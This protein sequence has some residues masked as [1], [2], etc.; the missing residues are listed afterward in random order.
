MNSDEIV[1]ILKLNEPKGMLHGKTNRTL[2]AF[3][4]PIIAAVR[5]DSEPIMTL[6]VPNNVAAELFFPLIAEAMAPNAKL[7]S[8]MKSSVMTIT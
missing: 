7:K 4:S 3:R 8:A 1:S 5:P 2:P 6:P